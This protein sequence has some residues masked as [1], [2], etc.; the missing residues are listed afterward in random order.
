M[1]ALKEKLVLKWCPLGTALKNGTFVEKK[2]TILV[3]NKVDVAKAVPQ[4]V[5]FYRW[6]NGHFGAIKDT[7]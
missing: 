2:S 3:P 6:S 4:K 7:C 5:L 1:P